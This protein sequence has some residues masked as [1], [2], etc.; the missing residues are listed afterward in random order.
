MLLL[1]WLACAGGEVKDESSLETAET[2]DDSGGGEDSIGGDSGGG[3]SGGGAPCGEGTAKLTGRILNVD[4]G[5]WDGDVEVALFDAESGEEGVKDT[6]GEDCV[7]EIIVRAGDWL[8]QARHE[9][10]EG[11]RIPITLCPG[12]NEKDLSLDCG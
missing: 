6:P 4:G 2:R 7:Y 8:Q 3:D 10:C 11:E 9:T 5:C 1:I 12:D